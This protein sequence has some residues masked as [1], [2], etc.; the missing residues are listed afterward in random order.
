M[1]YYKF[2]LL[3]PST[4]W[5]GS[6]ACRKKNFL[7]PQWLRNI[8][9]KKYPIWRLDTL[10]SKKKYNNIFIVKDGGWHFTN[11]KSPEDIEKKFLNYTHHYE[12]KLSGLKLEDLKKIVKEKKIIYDH[13]QDQTGY[14]WG[15]NATL[16][17]VGL[18]EMPD[19][20]KEN[21]QKYNSW[22]DI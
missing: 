16:N 18:S 6:K 12:F 20:L 11:I 13:S 1:F 3:Y 2:N 15:S 17:A 7:S 9:Q 10:L 8:R 5:F 19:Y 21:Y 14:K 4:A 22:L